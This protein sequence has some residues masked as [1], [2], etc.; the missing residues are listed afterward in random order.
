MHWR[1][2]VCSPVH[3]CSIPGV[4]VAEVLC[5]LCCCGPFSSVKPAVALCT[6]SAVLLCKG[7][8]MTGQGYAGSHACKP[9]N[10]AAAS[11]GQSATPTCGPVSIC[12]ALE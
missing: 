12:A 8:A 5:E 3:F 1:R 7:L 2:Y 6:V 4:D 9:A 11:G 10:S